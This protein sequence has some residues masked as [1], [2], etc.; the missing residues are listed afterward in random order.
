ALVTACESL[1]I[2]QCA[3]FRGWRPKTCT[4]TADWVW[5]RTRF[6]IGLWVGGNVT[7][8]GLFTIPFRGPTGQIEKI[9]GALSILRGEDDREGTG[10]PAQVL[11]CPCCRTVLAVPPDGFPQ[12]TP[13]T[14]HLVVYCQNPTTPTAAAMSGPQQQARQGQPPVPLF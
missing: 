5:G 9:W 3:N 6:S 4:N 8:N 10:E 1:R 7:P 2:K 12:A 14:L 11:K 13:A